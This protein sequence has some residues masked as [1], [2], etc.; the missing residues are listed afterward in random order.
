MLNSQSYEYI[1]WYVLVSVF[2]ASTLLPDYMRSGSAV[3]GQNRLDKAGP[4]SRPSLDL[5]G[6]IV[7]YLV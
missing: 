3:S 5:E 4:F 1:H 7:A 6:T 2:Q